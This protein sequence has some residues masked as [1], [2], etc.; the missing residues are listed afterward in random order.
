MNMQ[1]CNTSLEINCS[2][3]LCNN[4]YKAIDKRTH[5]TYTV[6]SQVTHVDYKELLYNQ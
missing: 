2:Q 1:T 4:Y 6:N 3:E 5:Y